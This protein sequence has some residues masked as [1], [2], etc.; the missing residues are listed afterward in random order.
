M[1]LLGDV[2]DNACS[3]VEACYENKGAVEEMSCRGNQAC[4]Q[5]T[6]IVK[7]DSWYVWNIV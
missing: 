2:N 5:Q 4:F 1:N 3:G 6:G 7:K